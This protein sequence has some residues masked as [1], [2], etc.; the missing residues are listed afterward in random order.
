[1]EYEEAIQVLKNIPER[2][3]LDAREKEAITL[4]LGMLAWAALSKSRLKA[5]KNRR[6][7]SAEW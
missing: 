5:Q 4:A 3:P 1:M 6:E 7:K 2:H